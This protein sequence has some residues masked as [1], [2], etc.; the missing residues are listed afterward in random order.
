[1]VILLNPK[2]E[3][4]PI[5]IEGA[6]VATTQNIDFSNTQGQITPQSEVRSGRNSNSSE[7]L[8][9]S[10]LPARTKKIPLE[11]KA[12]ERSQHLSHCKSMGIFSNAQGQLTPQS[13]I[14]SCR[15]LNSSEISWLSLLHKR[16]KKIR[17]NI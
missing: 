3:E 1:M 15:I 11:M 16:M 8:W 13:M 12:L 7:I 9:L 2:Y 5:K 4:D 14:K 17:S 6:T 10:L